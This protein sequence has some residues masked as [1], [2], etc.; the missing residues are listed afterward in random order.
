VLIAQGSSNSLVL[1]ALIAWPGAGYLH[2]VPFG[3]GFF[4]LSTGEENKEEYHEMGFP[5]MMV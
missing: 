2:P 5:K 1:K 3:C 4:G